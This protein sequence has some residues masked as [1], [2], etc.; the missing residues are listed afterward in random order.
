MLKCFLFLLELPVWLSAKMSQDLIGEIDRAMQ[1]EKAAD[2]EVKMC[3]HPFRCIFAC[4]QTHEQHLGQMDDLRVQDDPII[5][6]G[7]DLDTVIETR[8]LMRASICFPFIQPDSNP[9][10][11]REQIRSAHSEIRRVP[12]PGCRAKAISFFRTRFPKKR[13]D[14]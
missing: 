5:H 3:I 14:R 9:S 11:V 7:L 10:L 4:N 1:E 12:I 2:I 6:P 8:L 13:A